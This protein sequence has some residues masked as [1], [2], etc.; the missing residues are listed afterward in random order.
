MKDIM[1]EVDQFVKD[2]QKGNGSSQFENL[3][4]ELR[5]SLQYGTPKQAR[6]AMA[7][8]ESGVAAGKIKL[9]EAARNY[10]RELREIAQEED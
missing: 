2:C 3:P 1:G 4:E 8:V 10:I 9:G 5:L 7:I 6:T